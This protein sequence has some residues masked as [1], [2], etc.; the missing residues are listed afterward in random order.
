MLSHAI[1]HSHRSYSMAI[2]TVSSLAAEQN[3]MADNSDRLDRSLELLA[4]IN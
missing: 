2:F 1:T 3:L 4:L